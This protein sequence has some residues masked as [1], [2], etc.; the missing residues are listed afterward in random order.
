MTLWVSRPAL[1][2]AWIL[3]FL[4]AAGLGGNAAISKSD[5]DRLQN[6]LARI[7]DNAR[8]GH[9]A[10]LRTSVSEIELNSYLTYAL[11]S[12]LPEGIS[13][14]YVT[15]EGGGRLSGRAVVDLGRISSERSSGNRLDPL[16][17]FSGKAPITAVGALHT[18]QGTARFDLE[19]ATVAGV[20]VPS[21]LLQAVV[22]HYTRTPENPDG[23]KLNDSFTLPAG[24]KEI[25]VGKGQ[26]IVV[27]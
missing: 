8:A 2:C 10:A 22:S 21:L 24:I 3:L 14:P 13:E 11:A 12:D 5:A 16:S 9:P 7:A 18:K 20:S 25:E 6:K 23:V 19:S 27:Q 1:L 15:I 17:Y 4:V 26:T